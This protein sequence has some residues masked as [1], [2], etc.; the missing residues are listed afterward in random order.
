MRLAT[1]ATVPVNRF[2]MAEKPVSKGDPPSACACA[3]TGT[4]RTSRRTVFDSCK[5][6]KGLR[7]AG[8]GFI[9]CTSVAVN[10]TSTEQVMTQRLTQCRCIVQYLSGCV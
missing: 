5:D 1:F 9:W 3:A 2:C 4:S 6:R 8:E 7:H 10:L